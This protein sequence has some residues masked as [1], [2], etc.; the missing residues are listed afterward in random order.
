[1]K[2][3]VTII[4]ILFTGNYFAQD[5]PEVKFNFALE[6]YFN[7][8]FNEPI[9]KELPGFLYSHNRHNEIAINNLLLKGSYDAENVRAAGALIFGDYQRRNYSAEPTAFQYLFEA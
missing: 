8:D 2:N 5:N 7:F 9:D 4:I 1:M 3:I 6:S